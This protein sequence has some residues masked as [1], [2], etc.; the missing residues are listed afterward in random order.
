[1]K[2]IDVGRGI[3]AKQRGMEENLSYMTYVL[4]DLENMISALK[5][6]LRRLIR[7]FGA[8]DADD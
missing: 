8:E 2:R 6:E 5:D 7:K 4:Q 3:S 1:M